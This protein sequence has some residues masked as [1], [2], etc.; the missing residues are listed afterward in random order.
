MFR[1]SGSCLPDRG[2]REDQSAY[3]IPSEIEAELANDVTGLNA[4]TPSSQLTPTD[5][6]TSSRPT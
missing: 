1:I 3:A 2:V 4:T 6:E 5:D